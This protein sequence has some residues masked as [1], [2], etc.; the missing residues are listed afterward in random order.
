MDKAILILGL[1]LISS[2]A[3]LKSRPAA[4]PNG[5]GGSGTVALADQWRLTLDTRAVGSV[6]TVMHFD[7]TSNPGVTARSRPGA[8]RVVVGRWRALLARLFGGDLGQGAL[9]HLREG[10]LS[11]RNDTLF[12]EGRLVSPALRLRVHAHIADRRLAGTLTTEAGRPAGRIEG[13]PFDGDL[14]L[15]DYTAIVPRMKAA[16][17]EHIYDPAVLERPEWSSF[18]ERIGSRLR[19]AQDDI[20]ALFAVHDAA[21]GLGMSHFA[22]LRAG[23]WREGGAVPRTG[24]PLELRYP[25]DSVAH[26]RFRHFDRVT[27]EVDSAFSRIADG[28]IHTLIIDLRG[29]PGGDLSAMV[30]AAHLLPDP[31]FAGTFVGRRWW[32]THGAPPGPEHVRELPVL[33]SPDIDTFFRMLRAHGAFTGRVEPRAPQFRGNVLV[34]I[35]R[36][37][38]SAAEALAYVLAS[39]GRA[40]LIGERTAGAVLSA[41][42]IPLGDGWVLLLPTADF[43][44]AEGTRLEGRGVMPAIESPADKALEVALRLA[45][46]NSTPRKSM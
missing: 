46:T 12:L 37:T 3:P 31:V 5:P 14:P 16:L 6:E 44:T 38:A 11:E 23:D 18:W 10:R 2:C 28:A 30:V 34:L 9:L 36:T 33:T 1:A 20:E 17:E 26:L 40:T 13:T 42:E 27:E 24:P 8:L 7:W 41:K 35:D 19:Q 29:V 25:A 39:T 43:Y 15:R 21:R 22:L 45:V 32:R 4:T